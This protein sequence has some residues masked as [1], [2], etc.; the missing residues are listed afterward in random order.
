MAT[1]IGGGGVPAVLLIATGSELQ[2]AMGAAEVLEAEG[3]PTRVVSLPCWERFEARDAAY[4]ESVLP[5][6]VA[7]RV[8]MEM[9]VSL[10][11]E[12]YAGDAGAVLGID[13]FGASAPASTIFEEFG[14]TVERVTDVARGVVRGELRGR[15]QTLHPG[16]QPAG[17]SRNADYKEQ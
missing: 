1:W 9:G 13:H 12:R 3:T 5:R 8:T 11:W 7:A 16:H 17:L 2:L 10:G 6:A 14:F 4:R 15:V